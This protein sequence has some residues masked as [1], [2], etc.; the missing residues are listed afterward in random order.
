VIPL[1]PSE[2]NVLAYLDQ[3][4]T[5]KQI[6]VLMSI[7]VATVRTYCDRIIAKTFTVEMLAQF[8]IEIVERNIR[9]A[10]FVRRKCET[11]PC[12]SNSGKRDRSTRELPAKRRCKEQP[13]Q[14]AKCSE[15]PGP[16]C[17]HTMS[18]KATWPE[19]KLH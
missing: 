17:N 1:S 6:A 10:A 9:G 7:R 16:C 14:N 15:G 18:S 12:P 4:K 5:R 13:G 11:N 2:K 3:G 8:E 19:S